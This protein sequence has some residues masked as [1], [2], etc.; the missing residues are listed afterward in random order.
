MKISY[1]HLINSIT[2]KPT[3]EEVSAKLFQ[4]GHEN[5]IF[6]DILDI[7]ITPN[8]GDCLS[9]KGI[10]RELKVFYDI[11]LSL[12]LFNKEIHSFDFDFVNNTI[13]HCP[14]ISFLLIE[15]EDIPD[16]YSEYL[17]NYFENLNLKKNNFF[18]DV[19]NYLSYEMGQP[20]HCYDYKKFKS[21]KMIL[22]SNK[23]NKT[24]YSLLG[25]EIKLVGENLVFM[26]EKGNVLNLAGVIGGESTACS[27][28]TKH[29]LVE[30]GF[31]NPEAIIGKSVQYDI[32]SEASYKFERGVDPECHKTALKRFLQIIEDHSNIIK[33]SIYSSNQQQFKNII[34][35][36]DY[37]KINKI[38]GTNI[39]LNKMKNYFDRLGFKII[40]NEK[41]EVPSHRN[42]LKNI[43]DLSEEIARCVGYDNI[44][45]NDMNINLA[46]V[47]DISIERER[48][49]KNLLIHYGFNEVI[50]NPF[51]NIEN[52]DSVIV[53]NP[54]DVN[55]K[56]LRV[57]LK[58][59][60]I[61]NLIYNERRQKDSI[62][63][64]E[65]SN[66]YKLDSKNQRY[67]GIIVSG[68][69]GNN[70]LDFSKKLDSKYLLNIFKKYFPDNEFIIENIDRQTIGSKLKTEICYL[71]IRLENILNKNLD[72]ISLNHSPKQFNQYSQISEYPNSLR[73]ISFAVKD[74]V[75]YKKLEKLIMKFK[76][77]ILKEV[78]VF[79]FYN[80]EK[81]NEIK[82]GFRFIFQSKE[83]TITDYE[84]NKVMKEIIKL[85]LAIRS[86]SIPGL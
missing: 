34:V 18:T 73:D 6:D 21:K 50:N 66:T 31:F 46:N 52:E 40:G 24:F 13:E 80:N 72:R 35:P 54:L 26:D 8:R 81:T 1:R 33:A 79:D 10:L 2:E 43:N 9:I 74:A 84:V 19:S 58:D 42:D 41:I 49:L 75:A 45:S 56:Y 55:R 77:E 20:T 39:S 60:L 47:K 30:C 57:N 85:S 51:T 15:I 11:D 63:L 68:R 71:E 44:C 4:L 7:E 83:A 86:V 14:N 64:F 27:N 48:K 29:V 76:H 53:D 28:D 22:D 38:I 78:F 37:Q 25:K 67:I 59:S 3:I 36:F 82:I 70:Y 5:E 16:R 69:V 23:N 61:E 17:E 32:Q 12:N 65:I 62:K